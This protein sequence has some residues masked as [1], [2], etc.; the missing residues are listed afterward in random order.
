MPHQFVCQH[1]VSYSECTIGNHI[2]YSRYLDILERARGE[3]A[4][5]LGTPL[6]SLQDQDLIF[7]AME[8]QLKYLRP[9]RYDDVLTIRLWLSELDRVRIRFQYLVERES[10]NKP[11]L[12]G[13]TL[14]VCT[15]IHE[16]PKRIPPEISEKLKAFF[17]AADRT[18]TETSSRLR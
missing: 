12:T 11:I 4:R 3:F 2:Y 7:P 6:Q 10:D 1:R 14:H 15:S 18:Q 17:F 9:A 13:S 5:S 8:V 16:K